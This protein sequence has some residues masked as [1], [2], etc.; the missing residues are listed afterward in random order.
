MKGLRCREY[1]QWKIKIA[2]IGSSGLE[3][4]PTYVTNLTRGAYSHLNVHSA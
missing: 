4:L 1:S 2:I 3:Q